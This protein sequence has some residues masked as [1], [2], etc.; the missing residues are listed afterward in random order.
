LL[1]GDAAW[2]AQAVAEFERWFR[3]AILD[4][5]GGRARDVAARLATLE[6]PGAAV[7]LAWG[8]LV[9][10]AA[11][12]AHDLRER[13]GVAPRVLAVEPTGPAR[14]DRRPQG[15]ISRNPELLREWRDTDL[16]L[17]ALDPGAAMDWSLLASAVAGTG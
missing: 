16:V 2:P 9:A 3:V 5:S 7:V 8:D 14:P 17:L 11:E 10:V 13:I 6:A 12:A 4:V 15:I 1:R